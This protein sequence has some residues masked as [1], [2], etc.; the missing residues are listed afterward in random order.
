MNRSGQLCCILTCQFHYYEAF[1]SG[2]ESQ[3]CEH[4]LG[5]F[6]GRLI[7]KEPFKQL[8][9]DSETE[10]SACVCGVA[11]VFVCILVLLCVQNAQISSY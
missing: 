9:L 4:N 1:F 8:T 2:E 7:T 10:Y 6:N 11:C 5:R 3:K